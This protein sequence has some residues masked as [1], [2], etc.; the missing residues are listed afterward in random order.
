MCPLRRAAESAPNK[1]CGRP[2]RV[3]VGND[4]DLQKRFTGPR[5]S[6]SSV[7][8]QNADSR[9][10]IFRRRLS[11]DFVPMRQNNRRPPLTFEHVFRAYFEFVWRTL[12][13]FGIRE[14]D[15]VAFLAAATGACTAC[16]S[17][18]GGGP[19]SSD[20]PMAAGAGG[21][22]GAETSSDGPTFG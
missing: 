1:K 9:P 16:S 19:A 21:Q 12:A 5:V 4:L 10:L 20:A 14:V 7:V 18:N 15:L 13:R 17:S 11:E 8:D 22:E 2:S 6:Y 3:R